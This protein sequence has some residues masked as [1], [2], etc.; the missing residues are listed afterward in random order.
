[1]ARQATIIGQAEDINGEV[2]DVREARPTPHGFAVLLGWPQTLQR[3]PG[4]G[5]PRAILT[6]DLACYLAA[7]CQAPSGIDLPIGR[8]A[9]KRL[10]KLLDLNWQLDNAQWWHDHKT[11]LLASTLDDFC[12]RHGKSQGAAS[13]WRAVFGGKRY[14]HKS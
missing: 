14:S 7:H 2:W 9:V 5:G 12:Q 4:G 10:R 6:G 1:M 3:G 11:D 8:G 13:Q